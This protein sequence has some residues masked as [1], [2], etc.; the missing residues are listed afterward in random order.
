MKNS[1][2]NIEF[3]KMTGC[4]ESIV[5]NSDKDKMNWC[6]VGGN[7]GK[8]HKKNW[9]IYWDEELEGSCGKFDEIDGR[10]AVL[11][12]FCEE[13]NRVVSE[14][15]SDDIAVTVTRYFNENGNLVENFIIKNISGTVVCINRENLGIET[16]FDCDLVVAPEALT[17]HCNAH[18]WC[19]HNICWANA[20]KMGDS[21]VNLGLYL[22]KGAIESY[23][24]NNTVGK[25]RGTFVL[26]IESML[27]N[28][29]D[30]YE[31]EWELFCHKGTDD[32][33]SKIK[34]YENYI[35]IKAKHYTVFENEPIEFVVLPTSENVPVIT[36]NEE[37]IN[38]EKCENGYKII[39]NPKKMGEHKFKINVGEN[40]TT[41]KFNVKIS[42]KE[43]L[44][45]RIHFII[46]NQQCLDPKSPLYGAFLVYDN[47]LDSMYFDYKNGDHN[48]CRERMNIP[49]LLMKYLQVKNDPEV[50]KAMDLYMNFVFRE[51]Y[52]E[53]TGEV[54]NTIG[55]N[56]DA[57]RL[58]NA[59]GVML[60]FCEMYFVTRD[61]KYLE[62][63]MKLAEKYY[64]IGGE[65]CYANGLAIGKN[66]KAFRI[67]GKEKEAERLL[68]LFK[69]HIEN[70]ISNDINYP[71]HEVIYEQTIVTP[72][73]THISE[74]GLL[75]SEKERYL[76]EA[77]KHMLNL[78]RFSGMQPDFHLYEIALRYWDDFWFGK[79]GGLRA[80]TLPHHLSVLTA[81]A[82]IAYSRLSGEEKWM[83]KAEECIRNCMCLIADDGRGSAAYIYPHR[84]DGE[85][86]EFFDLFSNDQD[87]VLYDALYCAEYSDTFKI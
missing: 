57:L 45:N 47:E 18:I 75:S 53:T 86:G 37:K 26:G 4:I 21:Q 67:A 32:F 77:K 80:D 28:P 58:Y 78:E 25:S 72:A 10:K 14:Y 79:Y 31:I 24:Q 61:E 64:T 62:H 87:L 54:F 82:Y 39:Y 5:I 50:R 1:I 29:Q 11:A 43:L 48:A 27:L 85:K 74:M 76:K 69:F 55:K 41:V 40:S 66:I 49:L 34:K 70:I 83:D 8:I 2:F 20:L 44:E 6:N 68:E 33:F 60:L 56:R 36:L 19:G 73:V 9:S 35:G 38:A 23:D 71:P 81:R 17:Q 46:K 84:V 65:K 52:E 13:N 22:T 63:I 3:D 16:P 51:F 42:F 7:W 59:P 30:E 12:S 15:K